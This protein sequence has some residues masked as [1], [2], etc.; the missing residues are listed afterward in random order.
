MR[1]KLPFIVFE[2]KGKYLEVDSSMS[3]MDLDDWEIEKG[4]RIKTEVDHKDKDNFFRRI[5]CIEN[6]NK[7]GHLNE[8]TPKE[9]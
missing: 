8:F 9:N 2:T 6:L 1:K 3:V 4:K 7:F 5:T